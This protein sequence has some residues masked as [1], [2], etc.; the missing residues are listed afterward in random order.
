MDFENGVDGAPIRSTIPGMTFTTTM[1]YDWIYGDI[2]T[3]Q[4]NV[5]PYGSRA[6]EC[7][8]NFFAWLGPNQGSGRIDFTGAT[9]KSISMPTSTAYGTYLDAYDSSGNLLARSYAGPNIWTGTMSEIKVTTSNIAYVIVHDTGNYWL[10]DDLRV[11]DLLRET[12]AFQSA[13]SSNVFQTLDL[14][15]SGTSSTYH[16]T[17]DQLQTLEILLNWKGSILGIQVIRPNG[18][19]FSEIQSEYPPI[20][21]VVPKA[22]TGTWTII[23]TAID[24]PYNDYPFAIDVSSIPLPTDTEPPATTLNIGSPKFSDASGNVYISSSTL[25]TLTAEDNEG[26]TGVALVGYRIYN[27]TYDFGWTTSPLPIEFHM[28]GLADGEYSIDYNSTDN[29]GNT[30]PTNT[31]K[32]IL[33]NTAPSLTIETPLQN[34]ALQDGVTFTL[35]AW[36]LSG[37]ASV[38]FSIQCAQGNVISAEFQQMSATLG[39]DGKWHL[40]FDTRRLPDGFY[41][42]VANGTDVL[43]NWG[44]TTVPCSIRNWATIQMLP[45][46][47]NSKA[48]RT[49]PIRFSIRVKASVDPSQPFIYNEELTIKIYKI[50]SPS[51]ALLQTS[52]F[53]SGSTN[54]RIDTGRL[55]I[56]NFKTLSTPAT[57][58]VNIY[59]KGMLIGSFQFSTVK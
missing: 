48:G 22:E 27:A 57:Y 53:G 37:V 10:I 42:F 1:G 45:S 52:N 6:Y 5:N 29:V 34:A 31:Q 17:N 51:N 49:M 30:E 47:P 20:R 11:R 28:S 38:Q 44:T 46:T 43:G 32:V 2:R 40:Y 19:I 35:S 8:S 21:I 13:E 9:A 4:Y 56:T 14:I 7:H 24:V 59:R 36:D 18:T 58:L 3:G 26:G 33:D 15:N 39:L 16:F 25:L 12:N 54:Y 55:Y 50:A 23:V 41:L